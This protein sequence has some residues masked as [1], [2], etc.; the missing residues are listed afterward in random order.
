MQNLS[1][2]AWASLICIAIILIVLNVGLV[3]FLRYRPTINMRPRVSRD[4]QNMNRVVE[5][6]KDPFKD[7]R[8]QL[9]QLSDLVGR[10]K[11]ASLEN[12]DR[13]N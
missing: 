12:K 3:A 4:A 10:L 2:A 7:E 8:N 1:P 13:E 5:V 9:D 11:N 6:I